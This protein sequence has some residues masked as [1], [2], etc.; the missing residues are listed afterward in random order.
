MKHVLITV[1]ITTLLAWPS[2]YSYA[3]N[4]TIL[5]KNAQKAIKN[6]QRDFTYM[7]YRALLSDYPQSKYKSKALLAIGEYLLSIDHYEDSKAQFEAAVKANPVN[8]SNL[9]VLS[10]RYHIAKMLHSTQ[11]E[12][13]RIEII[14]QHRLSLIFRNSKEIHFQTPLGSEFKAIFKIDEIEFY[15]E[16]EQFE[17]ILF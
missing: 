13:L 3:S 8:D 9:F 16:G 4:E 11:E 5:Y 12:T 7:Q 6:N 14:N 1:L 17:E 2:P 15:L 10:C